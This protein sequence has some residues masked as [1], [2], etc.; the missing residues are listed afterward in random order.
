MGKIAILINKAMQEKVYNEKYINRLSRQGELTVYDKDD[1]ADMGYV[2][3]FVKDSEV[4]ITS[5]GTP[6]LSKE[7]LDVC[8]DLKAVLHAAGSVKPIISDELLK[9]KIRMTSSAIALGEGVAETAL[10]F[11]I[12]ACKGFYN[13]GKDTANGLWGENKAIVKDFY[14][15]T[16][17]VI[18]GG[19]VGR[20]MVKL[21]KNFHVDILMYDPTLSEEYIENLGAKKVELEKLLVDSDVISIHSPSIP[22]TDNMLNK[23]N[24]CLIKDG[25]VLINT[26]RGTVINEI[27]LIEELKKD[28]F[29]ACIDVTNPEP[30]DV[31]NELRYMENVIMTPH[32]AGAVNN[33]CK[34]IALHICEEM[35]RLI[36]G[37]KMK[38]EINPEDLSKLA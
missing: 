1:F 34:R 21:L 4:I 33:G 20:H 31:N 5:W 23:D 7:I 25:A 35:E 19:F 12:S 26:A 3:D 14:D 16:V 32:I 24:L 22:A 8:P 11:A 17:G 15:I 38:T 2:I 18:S 37:E 6:S 13:L 29:F 36:N 10:A 30:P 27:D 28:R 9:R